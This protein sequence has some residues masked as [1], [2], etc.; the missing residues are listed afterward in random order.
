MNQP[1]QNDKE[2]LHYY[3]AKGNILGSAHRKE[4]HDKGLI[5]KHIAY[6]VTNTR[7]QLLLQLRSANKWDNPNVWDKPGGH[8]LISE[9]DAS[10][11][12]MEEMCYKLPNIS[13]EIVSNK[14]FKES[15]R[16]ANLKKKVIL[17]KLVTVF[18]HISTRKRAGTLVKEIAHVDIFCG[19]YNGPLNPQPSEVQLIKPFTQ[20]E[21]ARLIEKNPEQVGPDTIEYFKQFASEIFK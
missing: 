1:A 21:L 4:I 6:L 19:K 12:F 20:E 7:N 15:V 17:T 9:Q 10:R 5:N 18:N 13:G 3:D 8:V 14:K 11:E 16:Q 2:I